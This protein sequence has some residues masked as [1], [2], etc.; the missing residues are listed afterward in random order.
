MCNGGYN[1][2]HNGCHRCAMMTVFTIHPCAMMILFLRKSH[3][4][5]YISKTQKKRLDLIKRHLRNLRTNFQVKNGM[6]IKKK[7][8]ISLNGLILGRKKIK[9]KY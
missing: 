5:D 1:K 3:L 6:M 9:Q 7:I 8:I 2:F 4:G